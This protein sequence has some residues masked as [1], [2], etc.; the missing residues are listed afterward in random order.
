VLYQRDDQTSGSWIWIDA[1]DIDNGSGLPGGVGASS[2]RAEQRDPSVSFTGKW[3]LITNPVLSGGTA[4][5]AVDLGSRSTISFNGAG[6]K[7]ITYTDA[8]SGLARVYL[9]GTL[10][11][12]V[13][14]YSAIDQPQAVGFD[15]GGIPPARIR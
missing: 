2:G 1:F 9:D 5:R 15:S 4:V 10:A 6:I 8:W 12:T 14:L 7:W 3:F 13:D 11:A